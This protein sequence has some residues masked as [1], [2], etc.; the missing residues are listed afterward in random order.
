MQDN[1]NNRWAELI[2]KLIALT[3]DGVLSWQKTERQSSSTYAILAQKT[4]I[5]TASHNGKLIKL[6]VSSDFTNVKKFRLEIASEDGTS[7]FEIPT[8]TSLKDLYEAINYYA[9][10]VKQYIDDLLK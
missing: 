2:S 5:Y 8:T 9:S 10:G 7:L 4:E 6:T 3:Q 1:S